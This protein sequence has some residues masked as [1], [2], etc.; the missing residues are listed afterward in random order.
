MKDETIEVTNCGNCPFC[1]FDNVFG[2]ECVHP[3]GNS[4]ECT[5]ISILPYFCPLKQ[6]SI[7]IKL[8]DEQAGK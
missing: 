6:Q 3:Q 5:N 1:I 7:T 8:K 2:W 4:D